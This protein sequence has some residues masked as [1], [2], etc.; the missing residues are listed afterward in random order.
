MLK[1]MTRFPSAKIGPGCQ[2]AWPGTWKSKY[3]SRLPSAS[4]IPVFP[5][6]VNNNRGRAADSWFAPAEARASAK[7]A[8]IVEAAPHARKS[9]RRS[10]AGDRWRELDRSGMVAFRESNHRSADI[11]LLG[12]AT[13]NAG[14][15]NP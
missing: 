9:R 1:K 12:A 3:R 4:T 7:R 11:I 6:D 2:V 15:V 14:R 5:C 8:T 13:V 10:L